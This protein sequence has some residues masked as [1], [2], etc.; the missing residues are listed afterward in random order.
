M[1]FLRARLS[2]GA[3]DPGATGPAAGT[4]AP[5]GEVEDYRVTID[6]AAVDYGDA[7]ASYDDTA[8]A[9]NARYLFDFG[10]ATSPKYSN[11]YTVVSGNTLYRPAAG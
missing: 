4:S 2:D 10:T 6:T 5:N 9:A 11:A 1:T 7:P 8:A 3:S